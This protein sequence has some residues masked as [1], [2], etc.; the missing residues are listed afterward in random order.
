MS[1]RIYQALTKLFEKHRI[2]FW[3]DAK[4][5]MRSDFDALEI[6][7]IEKIVLENNEYA[8]KY[9]ILREEPEQRFL[10]FRDGEQPA[11]LNNW[12]LD[13]Q[14]SH[15]VFRAD[16]VALWLAELELGPEFS[17]VIEQ[18][19]EFL[20]AVKRKE[21][22]RQLLKPD[23]T[24]NQIRL[25]MMAVCTG[26]E[27]RMEAIVEHLIDEDAVGRSEK[28]E[29]LKRVGLQEFLWEQMSRAFKYTSSAPGIRDF[30]IELFKSGYA[31]A[32]RPGKASH[33]SPYDIKLS[34]DALVFLKRWKDSRQ[35]SEAFNYFSGE[36]ESVLSI[37]EEIISRDFRELLNVDLF[38]LVDQKIISDLVKEVSA[39][40][41][42]SEEVSTWARQRR[43]GHWYKEYAHIYEAMDYGAQFLSALSG[44]NLSMQSF[45]QGIE[46]Y[47]TT[48][49]RIDQ[50]YRKFAFNT[51]S[52]GQATLLG[53]LSEQIENLYATNYLM[54]LGD[55]FQ[56]FVDKLERWDASPIM[57]QR[58]FFSRQ[59]GSF[60]SKEVKVCVIISDA[61]RFELGEEL[62][63]IINQE[64]RFTAEVEP[65]L[66]MLPSYTQLG[67]AA[68][69]PHTEL[70]IADNDSGLVSVDGMP[71]SGVEARGKILNRDEKFR[72]RALKAEEVLGLKGDECK[73]LIRDNDVIYIYQ[74][75]IDSTAHT[76]ETEDRA[77]EATEDALS[78]LYHL[79]KKLGSANAVNLL[80][81]ADHGFIYQTQPLE[82]SDFL[83]AEPEGEKV[84][85]KDRRFVL[86]KGL[87]PSASFKKF[88]SEQVGL[89]GTVEIQIPK[90]VNRLRLQGAGSRYVHGGATLQEIVIP[91]LKVKKKRQS[92]V[93]EV[94]VDIIRGSSSIITSGQLGVTFYQRTPVSDKIKPRVLR[95]GIYNEAGE[96]VSD[97][98]ELTFDL[99]ADNSRDR[100]IAVRFVLTRKADEAN[101]KEVIL[102]LEERHAGTSH[103]KEYR[104][105][106]YGVRRS[107]KSDF[108][109]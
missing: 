31:A 2:V 34:A 50:L 76:R 21:A 55:E 52:A 9:R 36:C 29:L 96:L 11:D 85:Y 32:L 45:A 39:R 57:S 30:V 64:D 79:I 93:T 42:S 74:N 7:G 48:W 82:Q 20:K 65:A 102:K 6:E 87:K 94:E 72:A 59:V 40:T 108:D 25:K 1:E 47:A 81:T 18:H 27:P 60:L 100:E 90:S 66:S 24:D 89:T 49:F 77:F 78:E 8:V 58:D 28:M 106:R 56:G 104:S 84:L 51:R 13:V 15:S 3:Y 38:K 103:Y 26:A 83:G 61:L 98:H 17:P 69:L 33:P 70:A 10:L 53:D 86:G 109:F 67:M 23:D 44:A 71:S 105:M 5:E 80:V 63:R 14:L 101:G 68:L 99:A 37:E 43:S 54:R 88:T 62:C 91:V 16:Q 19:G 75:R 41:V 22:L 4:R 46:R 35:F 92:D 73:E 95:A 107:F 12:L 97:S